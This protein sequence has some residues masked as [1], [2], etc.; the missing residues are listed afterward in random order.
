LDD[1]GKQLKTLGFTSE[2]MSETGKNSDLKSPFLG[3]C[4]A[5]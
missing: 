2:L 5:G 4:G 1:S 3:G